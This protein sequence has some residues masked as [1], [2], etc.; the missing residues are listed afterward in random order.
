MKKTP[1]TTAVSTAL[2]APIAAQAAPEVT[3]LFSVY[4]RRFI[5]VF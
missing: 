1:I 5:V 4:D 3:V 2:M